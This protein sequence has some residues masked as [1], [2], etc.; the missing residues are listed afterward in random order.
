MK[1]LFVKLKN[2]IKHSD[3]ININILII[4]IRWSQKFIKYLFILRE[5]LDQV[6]HHQNHWNKFL[7]EEDR[8]LYTDLIISIRHFRH[9]LE[10]KLNITENCL[11][12]SVFVFK[13]R[14]AVIFLFEFKKIR[15]CQFVHIFDKFDYINRFS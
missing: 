2:F 3:F 4:I 7:V 1:E 10:E 9:S 11:F 6:I 14:N 15:L 12:H 8:F 5:I 13:N